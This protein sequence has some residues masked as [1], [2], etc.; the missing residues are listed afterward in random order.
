MYTLIALG[1]LLLYWYML[2]RGVVPVID[3]EIMINCK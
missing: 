1:S 2:A 3:A